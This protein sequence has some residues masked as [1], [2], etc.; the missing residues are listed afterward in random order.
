MHSCGNTKPARICK[1]FNAL[2]QN[3]ACTGNG[4][5]TQYD[6]PYSNPGTDTRLWISI[7]A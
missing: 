3:Y 7:K 4:I 2:C 5:V 1:L 6:F